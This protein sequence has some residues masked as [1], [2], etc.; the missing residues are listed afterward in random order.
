[1]LIAKAF[2]VMQ[3]YMKP[4]YGRNSYK[5]HIVTL[6][7]NVQKIA[8]TLPNLPSELRFAVFQA[9]DRDNKNFNFKVRR[10]VFLKALC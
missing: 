1:M 10:N 4:R 6:P 3:V 8:G 2:A 7:H 5:G 9:R